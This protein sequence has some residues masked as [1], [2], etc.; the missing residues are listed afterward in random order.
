MAGGLVGAH[1]AADGASVSNCSVN[2]GASDLTVTSY[3]AAA[4]GV[5]GTVNLVDGVE[6]VIDGIT[7][8]NVTVKA[9]STDYGAGVALVASGYSATNTTVSN[10]ETT[11][12]G[13]ANA[14]ADAE[15]TVNGKYCLS[16][17]D[18]VKNA[19]TGD[20]IELLADV[21]CDLWKSVWNK[22]DLTINGNGHTVTV[23]A[24]DSDVNGGAMLRSATNLTIKNIKIALPSPA[25]GEMERVATMN[26]GTFENV[27]V[28]GGSFAFSVLGDNNVVINNCNFADINEWAIE[29]EGK[30]KDASLTISNSTFDDKA[31][32]IRGNNTVFTDNTIKNAGEGVNV[33]GNAVIKGNDFGESTLGIDKGVD[34]TIEENVINNVKFTSWLSGDYSKVTVENNTLSD[35]AVTEMNNTLEEEIVSVD[36]VAKVNGKGYYSF[37]DAVKNAKDTDGD[38]VVTIEVYGKAVIGA[39]FQLNVSCDTLNIVGM[40]AAAEI[41]VET[42]IPSDNGILYVANNAIE[43]LNFKDIKL[44]RPNGEWRGNEGHH[45]R[46]FTVWDNDGSADITYTNCVFPNGAGNN[47][48]GK[49]TYTG[50][51]FN[52][53]SYYALWIYG[54]ADKG[55]VE[56]T[57]CTFDAD[58]GVKIYSEDGAAKVKTTIT[59]STFAIDSKPAIVSSIAGELVIEDVDTSACKYGLLASEPKDGRAD[60]EFAEITVDGEEPVY[61]AQVGNMVCTDMDYAEAE[62]TDA[63]P[64]EAPVAK[65]GTKYYANLQKAVDSANENDVIRVFAGTYDATNLKITKNVIITGD[66]SY[67]ISTFAASANIEK[68]VFLIKEVA[69]GGIKY[70]ATNVTFDNIVFKV[71]EDATRT[72]GYYPCALGYFVEDNKTRNTLTV[73]DCDFVNNSSVPGLIAIMAHIPN[74]TVTG[75]TF[76]NF[77]TVIYTALDNSALGTVNVSDNTFAKVAELYTG[78][79]G[80]EN[81]NAVLTISNNKATD[82]STTVINVYDYAKET[83]GATA[84]AFNKVT[85]TDNDAKVILTN[86]D[87]ND[88]DSTISGND[89]VVYTYKSKALLDSVDYPKT[90]VY[91]GYNSDNEVAYLYIDGNLVTVPDAIK[92]EFEAAGEE[93]GEKT[94]NI[95]LTAD[96]DK[97]INRLNSVDLTFVL[98]QIKG[99]NEFEI[100]ASNKEVAINPVDNSKVRYEFHYNGKDG[101]KTDSANTITIGQVKFTGYGEFSFAVNKDVTTNAAHA[102]TIDDNIVDTFIPDGD[103]TVISN[104]ELVIDNATTGKIE[105]AVP[106]RNLTINIDFPNGIENK[107]IAYQD[108]QAVISGGDLAEDITID[109]GSDAAD[110]AL[111]IFGKKDA[112]FSV[113]FENGSYVINVTDA[114]T[115][116]NAYTVTISG[117][118]YRTARY[119]VT[120]TEDKTLRFWNNVMDEA[121]FVEIGK[122]SSKVNVT[123]LAG[124]IVKDNNINIYD[125]SAVVSYFGS[126]ATVANKYA[127]YDLNRDGIIDSKDVAYVLVSWGK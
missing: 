69:D 30:A 100:I 8:S 11:L 89:S 112:K 122:E 34:V 93:E 60:L 101:V 47:Q 86:Y 15:A 52:N 68:P 62:K 36:P 85:V 99:A 73:T 14:P 95:N 109:L 88:F 67:G 74:Y 102:T 92:V 17:Y 118:G 79:W 124:D 10:V 83:I 39:T 81:A 121:Q 126:T 66:P 57:D 113:K 56:V 3:Y 77:S 2:G 42:N 59:D 82:D 58:R 127:K 50:C 117:A 123:Y 119:T 115:L 125:L 70:Q 33:L 4:G 110:T 114:L 97:I 45:N 84:T 96:S 13:E 106:D 28:T 12:A 51:T 40:N 107:E 104:G 41:C 76:E 64:I 71:T 20:K 48:Y 63:K 23:K 6:P 55:V 18:A 87:T 44:S 65:V 54:S 116:N 29:T 22:T 105:I 1:Y 7:V 31:V 32:I 21:T 111:D 103:T 94:Y 43:A 16:F 108:M 25:T 98:T 5:I 27:S 9:D 78:Y 53:P 37:G 46:F 61:V 90:K 38:G 72:G 26:G 120:M 35:E 49:T 24:I 19:Q 75:C 91:V 80:K